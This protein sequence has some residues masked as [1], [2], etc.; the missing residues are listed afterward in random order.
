MFEHVSMRWAAWQNK[1]FVKT[2]SMCEN[3]KSETGQ[4][5]SEDQITY[6]LELARVLSHPVMSNSLYTHGL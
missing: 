2:I 6:T 5:S 1:N 3:E 4:E